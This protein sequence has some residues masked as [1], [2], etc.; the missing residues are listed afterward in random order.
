MK[1][2]LQD[3]DIIDI[4]VSSAGTTAHPQPSFPETFARLE[5]YGCDAS[6]HQQ[7]KLTPEVLEWKDIVICMA[8]H[9]RTVVRELW[10]DAVLFNEL[11]YGKSEDL[12]DDTEYGE[13]YGYDYDLWKYVDFIVDYIHDAIPY[14]V[15][16]M[17]KSQ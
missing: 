12:L 16:N 11:T 4:S 7:T 10:Y 1:K 14:I 5:M 13:K 9:H 17:Q 2:Y 6:E 3:R 15:Q 8:E